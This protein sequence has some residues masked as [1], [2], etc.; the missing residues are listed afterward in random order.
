[1]GPLRDTIAL[2]GNA[3]DILHPRLFAILTFL[4]LVVIANK[5]ICSWVCQFG[6]LQ[7][8]LFRL[9]RNPEDNRG[10]VRQYKLPFAV[11]NS[12]RVVFFAAISFISFF[13]AFNIIK[14]I[15]PFGIFD[16][17]EVAYLG[18][19]FIVCLLV[20]SLFIYRPW[21]HLFCPFGLLG[22]VFEKISIYKIKVDYELCTACNEC[23]DSCPSDVMEAILKRD[24]V[25]PD[26]FA[27]GTCITECPTNA[28]SFAAGKRRKPPEG[29][30]AG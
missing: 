24:E 2:F 1:M 6:V 20:L 26:C 22:W 29:K 10:L 28:I 4:A 16:P 12:V 25:L 5:F 3:E 13:W 17:A 21:C 15:D 7:D 19:G 9:N 14:S 23:S 30:F 11:S 8:F 27:C 18:W